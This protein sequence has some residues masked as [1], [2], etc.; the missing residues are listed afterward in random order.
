[1]QFE[2]SHKTDFPVEVKVVTYVTI[3][4]YYFSGVESNINYLDS[5]TRE[6]LLDINAPECTQNIISGRGT[7]LDHP[8]FW[9]ANTKHIYISQ[10]AHH[11]FVAVCH[12]FL[13][14]MV[15]HFRHAF[16]VSHVLCLNDVHPGCSS[17]QFQCTISGQCISS[18]SRCDGSR[19]CTD[20]SDEMDC[21]ELH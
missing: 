15:A 17:S 6:M 7:P 4:L 12:E 1:M 8:R 2:D 21:S 14:I 20:G 9:W 3:V 10:Q 16:L 19:S 5:T 13:L 18:S 11:A